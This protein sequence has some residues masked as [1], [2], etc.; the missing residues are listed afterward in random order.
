[1]A[2]KV[3]NRSLAK[4][5]LA[6]VELLPAAAAVASAPSILC[7]HATGFCK[8]VFRPIVH[9]LVASRVPLRSA[10]SLDFRGHGERGY[11]HIRSP[12]SWWD[13]ARDAR[14]AATSARAS[15]G[16]RPLVGVGH[17]KGATAL[18]L[19]EL[20]KPGT[21]DALVLVEP[22]FFDSAFEGALD[23]SANPM[24]PATKRRRAVFDDRSAAE[25]Y[26]RKR[27]IWRDWD[28]R[29]LE[30][31]LTHGLRPVSDK[32]RDAVRADGAS[33]A[34]AL[35]AAAVALRCAPSFEAKV[36]ELGV[37][38]WERLAEI[39]CPV[40]LIVGAES[41]HL[42]GVGGGCTARY[43]SDVVAPLFRTAPF[44]RTV[45]GASHFVAMEQPAVIGEEIAKACTA[46]TPPPR[47]SAAVP[48]S[49][50]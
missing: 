3:S 12:L 45:A 23:F 35:G 5:A 8:E 33:T 6:V 15:T 16:G 7:A 9:E 39:T 43:Y 36:Y 44:V 2:T 47:W 37:S 42:D 32:E 30:E 25:H 34:A 18:T 20:D 48:P 41:H 38:A 4:N 26:F 40:T 21:F 24:V 19:A 28:E 29:A 31:Y 11:E 1:M 14:N 13:F 27:S 46:L 17:S 10:T 50:L 22:I 49:R